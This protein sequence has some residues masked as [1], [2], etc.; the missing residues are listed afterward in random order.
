MTTITITTTYI[1]P[2]HVMMATCNDPTCAMTITHTT[3]NTHENM[4]IHIM[5]FDI[6][7]NIACFG[8]IFVSFIKI[9]RNHER[10]EFRRNN[11][12]RI[13]QFR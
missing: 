12:V 1:V 7:M 9:L 5:P 3:R 13:Q 4:K 8:R 11:C 6:V 2:T 10:L